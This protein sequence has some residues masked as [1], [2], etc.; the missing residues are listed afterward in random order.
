MKA[1]IVYYKVHSHTR[2]CIYRDFIN[3]LKN[4]STIVTHAW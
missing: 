3:V 2:N 1:Q 4:L